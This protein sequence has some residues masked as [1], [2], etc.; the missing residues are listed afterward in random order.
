[1]KRDSK[2]LKPSTWIQETPEGWDEYRI[3]S[4][5][6][7]SRR[8]NSSQGVE[9]YLSLM[10]NVGVIPFAEKGNVG[11]KPPEDFGNCKVAKRGDFVLNTMNFGIGSFGIAPQDGILS[12][13]YFVLRK[14]NPNL[15][16]EF[17]RFVFSSSAFREYVQMLGSGILEHRAAIRW[18]KFK[19]VLVPVPEIQ[20]QKWRAEYLNRET[21]Q[22]DLLISKK[23][24]L[25]EKLLER[26]QTLITQIVTKGL[27][28]NVPVKDSGVDWLGRVPQNWE[29]NKVS[30]ISSRSRIPAADLEIVTAFRDGQVTLRSNRRMEGFTEATQYHG[31]QR[32]KPGQVAVHRMDAFAG[33]IGVSDSEGMCS[34]VLNLLDCEANL[35]PRFLALCLREI[36]KSGWIEA[37]A[38]SVRERTSEFGWSELAAQLVAVPPLAD[39]LAILSYLEEETSQIDILTKKAQLG[40]KL[41]KERR[42]ALITQVVTGK[43]EVRGFAGGDS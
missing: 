9:A 17:L 39:Q 28:P 14:V 43:L 38:K 6:L 30:Y 2:I 3:D 12:P 20:E 37:L 34:P 13:V 35:D 1:M 41:L 15:D 8:K 7:N 11:N 24:K 32:I 21:S 42:Q 22:I 27:D 18:E 10:A 29:L 19:T 40:I 33:A 25:I 16:A 26:R 23:E 36:S 31:Y 4:I 5:F